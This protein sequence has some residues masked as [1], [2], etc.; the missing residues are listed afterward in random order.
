MQ[1]TYFGVLLF[2]A[3]VALA[4]WKKR[5]DKMAR[6]NRGLS[7]YV[8]TQKEPAAPAEVENSMEAA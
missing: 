3:L 2:L 7:S 5:H 4:K 8:T 6:M 1:S